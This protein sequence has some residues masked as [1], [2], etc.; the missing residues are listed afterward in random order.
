[1]YDRL[2]KV[3]PLIDHLSSKFSS[4]YDPSKDVAVDE[5]VIKFQRRSALKQ[6]IPM[7]PISV[8][9]KCG[10]S[11]NGYFSR[12]QVYTSR[13]ETWEVGLGAHVVKSLTRDLKDKYHDVYFDNFFT[14]AQLLEEL[15]E[16]G[17]MVVAQCGKIGEAFHLTKSDR[18]Y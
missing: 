9:S 13:Q 11:T 8:G 3:R 18:S 15:E 7:K 12:F 5:A 16:D 14:S 17:S 1:M 6:Y 2:G 10:Y 4:L